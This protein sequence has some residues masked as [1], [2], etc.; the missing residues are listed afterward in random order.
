MPGSTPLAKKLFGGTQMTSPRERAEARARSNA[1]ARR[2]RD[3]LKGS[4]MTQEANLFE[5]LEPVWS[6][7]D[8][9]NERPAEPEV[10]KEDERGPIAPWIMPPLINI[11]DL[12]G[13]GQP[14]R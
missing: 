1:A 14:W 10:A 12:I 5:G 13:P 2:F 3:V 9:W 8:K 7:A 4:G 11:T 6:R